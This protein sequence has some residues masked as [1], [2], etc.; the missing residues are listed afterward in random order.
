MKALCRDHAVADCVL[1]MQT[2]SQ[3]H[4]P[5]SPGY[6]PTETEDLPPP[7]EYAFGGVGGPTEEEDGVS[8]N[9]AFP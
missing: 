1:V 4:A 9:A 5:G 7:P 3:G 8:R 2:T 6:R